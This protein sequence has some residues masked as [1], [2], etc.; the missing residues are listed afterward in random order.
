[1]ENWEGALE[2]LGENKE[3]CDTTQKAVDVKLNNLHGRSIKIESSLCYLRGVA[4][5]H[6]GSKDRAKESF[7]EALHTDCHCFEVRYIQ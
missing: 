1:M 4:F 2:L 5:L 3:S 7:I 6:Q